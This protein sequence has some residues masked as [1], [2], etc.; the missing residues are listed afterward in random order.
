MI[1]FVDTRC[2]IA[3][4]MIEYCLGR[5]RRDDST[6]KTTTI[7][8]AACRSWVVRNPLFIDT[9]L[10]VKS[11]GLPGPCR[12]DLH[13]NNLPLRTKIHCRIQFDNCFDIVVKRG[14]MHVP[15]KWARAQSKF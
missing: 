4:V 14:R 5:L 10:P 2:Y 1:C 11:M 15:E 12:R 9:I 8:V 7:T 3:R 13:P 6:A